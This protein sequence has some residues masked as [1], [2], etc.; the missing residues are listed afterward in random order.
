ME[1][2]P[3]QARNKAI[4]NGHQEKKKMK[5]SP[6]MT[7]L[8]YR[9]KSLYLLVF[10]I[11]ILIIPWMMTCIMMVHPVNAPSSTQMTPP[12]STQVSWT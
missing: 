8:R 11:A 10:Y 1:T 2:R 6:A 3:S 4:E 9:S 7:P 5:K 12:I